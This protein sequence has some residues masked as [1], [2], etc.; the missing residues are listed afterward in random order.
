MFVIDIEWYLFHYRQA[1]EEQWQFLI[2][3]FVYINHLPCLMSTVRCWTHERAVYT[4]LTLVS[5]ESLLTRANENVCGH[6]VK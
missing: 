2:S 4:R 3:L 1:T 5:A 6:L